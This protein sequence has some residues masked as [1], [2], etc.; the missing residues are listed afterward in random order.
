[1]I[2]TPS[3]R[4]GVARRPERHH[5]GRLLS[6]SVG[7]TGRSDSE[8]DTVKRGLD[9]RIRDLV[10]PLLQDRRAWHHRLVVG[11]VIAGMAATP[12]ALGSVRNRAHATLRDRIDVE[13]GAR[14][15]VLQPGGDEA[16]PLDAR[17]VA[18]LEA[19][20]PDIRAVGVYEVAVGVEGPQ[21][22]DFLTLRTLAPRDPRQALLRITPQRSAELGLDEVV[23]SDSLGRLLYGEGWTAGW[24]DGSFDGPP[25]KLWVHGVPLSRRFQVVARRQLPGRALYAGTALGV[26]LGRHREGLAV[27]DLGL[28]VTPGSLAQTRGPLVERAGFDAVLVYAPRVDDVREI[29]SAMRERLP[30]HD[31]RYAASDLADLERQD[32]LLNALAALTGCHAVLL[33]VLVVLLPPPPF[34]ARPSFRRRWVA[35]RFMVELPLLTATA[36]GGAAA[37]AV[38]LLAAARRLLPPSAAGEGL[39]VIVGSLHLEPQ[40]LLQAIGW[41]A[42]CAVLLATRSARKTVE[43]QKAVHGQPTSLSPSRTS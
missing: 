3:G 14:E 9:M 16:P 26:A 41:I 23:V 4:F 35:V 27:P 22:R 29:A 30:D 24:R 28:P 34:E 43:A 8:G 2:W 31:V 38:L 37:I 32:A 1:M 39:E 10:R 7:A 5:I 19:T 25:L 6:S 20:F 12:L 11:L 13:S 42:L 17:L 18:G 40:T 36:T 15:I 33:V 21:G